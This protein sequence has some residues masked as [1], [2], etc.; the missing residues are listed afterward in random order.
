MTAANIVSALGELGFS[1][2]ESRAYA[3][4]LQESPATGYEVGVRAQ[5]PRSAVYGVLRR[6][7]R[8]GAARSIAGTPE[9]FVPSPP[10]EV[11]AV[12]KKRFAASAE[13]LDEAVR[14]LGSPPPAPEAFTV[15]D[16]ER[17]LEEAE[18]LVR[19]AESRVIVSGWARE[20]DA[21][22]PELKRAHKRG[23]YVVVFSHCALGKVPGEV[24]SYGLAEADLEAFWKHRLIV[25]RDDEETLVGATEKKEGD[26]A[27]ISGT[28]AIAE[29]V[30]GQVALDITLLAQRTGRNVNP[31]MAKMLGSR[32]GRLD[33][34]LVESKKRR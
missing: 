29:V 18:R 15:R 19:S 7:E 24:H 14:A 23:V 31:V 10:T 9:R 16:Y 13:A 33:S 2:N 22:L 26:H 25:V 30:T 12:L 4:L 8:A 20:I 21:L 28:R 32:V 3:A 17:V 11:L 27:V 1:L 6:L 5:I 34:L